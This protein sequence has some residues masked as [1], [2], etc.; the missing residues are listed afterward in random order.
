MEQL[1]SMYQ[2]KNGSVN[3]I[4]E[5][6]AFKII[7][8]ENGREKWKPIHRGKLINK[9]D[10]DIIGKYNAEIRGIYNYYSIANNARV[11]SK[12]AYIT[13][14]SMYKTFAAKYKT[15]RT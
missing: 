3:Y 2:L 9:K 14:Y 10:I 6:K 5:Y 13:E 11:L 15:N 8:D 1:R 7:K 4:Q 12:F